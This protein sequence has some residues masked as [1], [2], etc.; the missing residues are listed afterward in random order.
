M[1]AFR[2]IIICADNIRLDTIA[3]KVVNMPAPRFW[4]SDKRAAIVVAAMTKGHA[5]L[6]QMNST[7]R[8]MY[9]EIYRRTMA[10]MRRIPGISLAEAVA[11]V[12]SSPAPRFYLTPGSARIIYYRSRRKLTA[13]HV[14]EIVEKATI[15]AAYR[16]NKKQFEDRK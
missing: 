4:V 6:A 9:L 13:P 5:P 11:E 10:L 12:V 3:H 1:L 16:K 7:K 8:D 15:A 14:R 2:K